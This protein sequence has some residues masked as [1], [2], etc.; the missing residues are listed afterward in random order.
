MT[1]WLP[2]LSFYI[3]GA[4]ALGGALLAILRRDLVVNALGLVATI[5]GLAG[6]FLLLEAPFLAMVQA[7]VYAGAVMVLFLFVV[8]LMNQRIAKPERR[9]AGPFLAALLLFVGFAGLGLLLLRSPLPLPPPPDGQPT[10][11]A[12]VVIYLF[13][14]YL[15]VVELTAL[16]IV[17]AVAGVVALAERDRA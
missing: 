15:P 6:L 12:G 17:A 2:E 8:M 9:S 1:N 11:A 5:L 7:V 4:V 3:F 13:R 14:E 16:V 10:G